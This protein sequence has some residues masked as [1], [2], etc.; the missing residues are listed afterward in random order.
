[1][2][3][4]LVTMAKN[5]ADIIESFVRHSLTYVDEIIVADHM[6]S[7]RTHEILESLRAEGLPLS[8]VEL[9]D[10]E[11][12]HGCVMT[13]LMWEAIEGHGA[14]MVLPADVDEFLVSDDTSASCREILCALDTHKVYSLKWRRY[15][16]LAGSLESDFLLM[17]P[18]RREVG[19][20]SGQK[21]IV[22][23][24]A[25]REQCFKL[26]QGCHYAYWDK[27][28]GGF[29]NVPMEPVPYLHVAHYHWRS[30]AQYV[31]KIATSWLNNVARYSMFTPTAIFLK[32][33]FD[34][35][36]AGEHIQPDNLLQEAEPF[37]LRPYVMPQCLRYTGGTSPDVLANLMAAAEQVA[38]SCAERKFLLTGK[39]V[40]FVVPYLGNAAAWQDS[41]QQ[42]LAQT[43]PC[44]EILVPLIAPGGEQLVE[45]ALEALTEDSFAFSGGD[46]FQEMQQTARGDFVQWVLP[47]ARLKPEMAMRMATSLSLQDYGFSVLVACGQQGFAEWSPYV[48]ILGKDNF[49][50]YN[51]RTA[52]LGLLQMGKK[53]SGDISSA[54]VVRSL[55]DECGW[56]KGGFLDARPLFYVMWRT[57]LMTGDNTGTSGSLLGVMVAPF[58]HLPWGEINPN[59]WL[60]HQLE[61]LNLLELD[62]HELQPEELREAVDKLQMNWHV[63]GAGLQGHESVDVI[64]WQQYAEAMR[65]YDAKV[66]EINRL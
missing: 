59:D 60:W 1:M 15:E 32:T 40:S 49:Q 64:L 35:L 9:Y 50:G 11:L 29:I 44:R 36:R 21:I 7:D 33:S 56:F 51:R 47:G 46:V 52:W 17:R 65:C 23:A 45:S 43:C 34:K 3:I 24:E 55:M 27:P 5:E 25:V 53:P 16:P 48:N 66:T 6:S 26:V 30:E 61:W 13:D 42:V 62:G 28:G 37:D 22:G 4:V 39:K 19:F 8:I 10:P 12:A 63:L 31:S 58:V 2:K 14:D 54:M 38:Q 20:T 57:L 41:L 18:C